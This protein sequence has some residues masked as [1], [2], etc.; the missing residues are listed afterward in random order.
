VDGH[1]VNP[2][3]PFAFQNL[4]PE[5]SAVQVNQDYEALVSFMTTHLVH[6]HHVDSFTV[7]ASAQVAG[8]SATYSGTWGTA[9][10]AGVVPV[11]MALFNSTAG[12]PINGDELTGIAAF[13]ITNVGC[14]VRVKNNWTSALASGSIIAV[15]GFD[16]T[17]DVSQ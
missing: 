5:T 1:R 11:V 7:D 3:V 4:D 12:S 13:A 6:Q 15:I 14:S 2:S 17:F 10:A 16:L 9:F 8:S